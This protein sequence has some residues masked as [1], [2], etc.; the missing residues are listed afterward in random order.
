MARSRM[1]QP[2][3]CEFCPSVGLARDSRGS[4]DWARSRIRYGVAQNLGDAAVA[5]IIHV[6]II[7]RDE[8]SEWN[9]GYFAPVLHY[10]EA[11][12]QIHTVLLGEASDEV[13]HA[14]RLSLRNSLGRKLRID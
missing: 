7:R 10:G 13:D 3:L 12:E 14:F 1:T 9:P 11:A 6:Q 5:P 4:K 8:S 2:G